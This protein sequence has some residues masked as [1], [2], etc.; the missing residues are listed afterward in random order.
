MRTIYGLLALSLIASPALAQGLLMQSPNPAPAGQAES[1][2]RYKNR[3]ARVDMRQA[4][5]D[6]AQ[7]QR[8]AAVGNYTGAT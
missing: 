8:D 1:D 3:N 4:H 5:H 7:A 6:E 2:A